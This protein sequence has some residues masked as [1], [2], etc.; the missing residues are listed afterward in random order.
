MDRDTFRIYTGALIRR[1]ALP[2]FGGENQ[3]DPSAPA[4]AEYPHVCTHRYPIV[5][6]HPDSDGTLRLIALELVKRHELLQGGPQR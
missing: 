2:L 1:M 3:V 5:P 4:H 6:T